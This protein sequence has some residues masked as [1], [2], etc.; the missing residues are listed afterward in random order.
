MKTPYPSPDYYGNFSDQFIQQVHELIFVGYTDALPKIRTKHPK[1]DEET[2]ITGFIAAALKKRQRQLG[3]RLPKY[4]G[5]YSFHEN[6]PQ[7]W[8][9]RVGKRR[10][11]PD[12]VITYGNDGA[13]EFVIEAKRLHKNKSN[14]GQ[15]TGS[16]GM[17]C[18]VSGMYADRY[19]AAGMLGY[20]QSDTVKDWAT[21]L[22]KK[23]LDSADDLSLIPPLTPAIIHPG[24]PHEWRSTHQRISLQRPLTIYHILLDCIP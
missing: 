11:Q 2:S 22:Q 23:I 8:G 5:M 15:Y 1:Y 18:F 4:I 9:D 14:V 19:N 12:I 3:E 21:K 13:P 10:P 17:G 20:V 24:L 6:D 16:D 7:E